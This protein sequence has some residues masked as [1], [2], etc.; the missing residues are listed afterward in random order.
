ML[1]L[2]DLVPDFPLVSDPHFAGKLAAKEEF[3]ELALGRD[4][5]PTQQGELFMSQIFIERLLAAHS[6]IRR[7]LI[8]HSVGTGKTCAASAVAEAYKHNLIGPG[9][10]KALIVTKGSTVEQNFKD[11]IANICVA[12][13]EY[14]PDDEKQ[15]GQTQRRTAIT[16]SIHR[17]YEVEHYVTLAKKISKMSPAEIEIEYSDRVIIIDEAHNLRMGYFSTRKR[18]KRVSAEEQEFAA[19]RVYD[20]VHR[21]LHTAKRTVVLLLTATPVVDRP[22]EMGLLMNLLLEVQRQIP[23]DYDWENPDEV[24]LEPYF[25]GLISYVRS[26]TDVPVARDQGDLIPLAIPGQ[27][28]PLQV[29]LFVSRMSDEQYTQYLRYSGQE[30]FPREDEDEEVEEK[31]GGSAFRRNE[32]YAAN[33]VFPRLPAEDERA[34]AIATDQDLDDPVVAE[35]VSR[36]IWNEI[37]S[38]RDAVGYS[39]FAARV[40][41][42]KNGDSYAIRPEGNLEWY[43]QE[44][45]GTENDLL[46]VLSCKFHAV[47]Q[48]VSA[49]PEELAFAYIESVEGPGAI[50]LA[51]TFEARGYERYDGQ[52][53]R[54][55]DGKI[56][57]TAAPRYAIITGDSKDAYRK[58]ALDMF[59]DPANKYGEYLQLVVGSN[60]TREGIS[61]RNVRQVHIMHPFWNDVPVQ[62]AIGRAFRERAQVDLPENERYV[63]V[64][65]H[66]AIAPDGNLNTVDVQMY[67]WAESKRYRIARVMRIA[68]RCACDCTLNKVRNQERGEEE[69]SRSCDYQSCSYTC[70]GSQVTATGE[71]L[72]PHEP[73][74]DTYFLFY[75]DEVQA[76]AKT[77]LKRLFQTQVQLTL[78]EI[79]NDP[80]IQ[81]LLVKIRG[82]GDK[83][84]YVLR[85]LN[86]MIRHN[87]EVVAEFGQ[88]AYLKELNGSYFLQY[89]ITEVQ[90]ALA[91]Y[92]H[93]LAVNE[94]Q[95]LSAFIQPYQE[96]ETG[97]IITEFE[98][99][100]R[101]DP[102]LSSDVFKLPE[103]IKAA[104]LERAL[105]AGQSARATPFQQWLAETLR[106]RWYVTDV[107]PTTDQEEEIVY[108]DILMQFLDRAKYNATT[109]AKNNA[110][111]IR[112]LQRGVWSFAGKDGLPYWNL[113]RTEEDARRADRVGRSKVYGEISSSDNGFRLINEIGAAEGVT[114]RRRVR[115]GRICE[116]FNKREL[117]TILKYLNIEPPA[118]PGPASRSA[119]TRATMVDTLVNGGYKIFDFSTYSDEEVSLIYRWNLHNRRVMCSL[120]RRHL[121]NN[122]LLVTN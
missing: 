13:G 114:D 60:V 55:I 104:L 76:E 50:L 41:V 24:Y 8:I 107:N 109:K 74:D 44:G 122:D 3:A 30:V 1:S 4:Q 38:K 28:E 51:L 66:A 35:A 61:F 33:F 88:T 31:S 67:A 52:P 48:E 19:L 37:D 98:S 86:E 77:R 69:G 68:K 91:Q 9:R 70:I 32:L 12:G 58:N 57:Q 17:Y 63:K 93:Q 115:R 101:D 42:S 116:D 75:S 62:Q 23:A 11:T 87:E 85:A 99:S 6:T 73:N 43:L 100:D 2:S 20:N 111:R 110:H 120:I 90:E 92:T 84:K 29:R 53:L 113:M 22:V 45:A 34:E 102:N 16:K 18:R 79:L 54:N 72:P 108:H 25:R 46:A 97:R 64:Y 119:A 39:A 118:P 59:R 21:M 36:R 83:A 81:D 7:Q 78:P 15:Y 26:S 14:L 5:K 10:K 121:E 47:L 56:R 117:I 106:N 95:G 105:A 80:L 89:D 71:L 40:A 94:P 65:Q 103:E 27:E 112:I 49:N 96:A 82:V